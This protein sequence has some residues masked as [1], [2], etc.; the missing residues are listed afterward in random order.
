MGTG[1]AVATGG[2]LLAG[3]V[4]GAAVAGTA[5]PPVVG[6]GAGAV[7]GITVETRVAGGPTV[8]PQA[9]APRPLTTSTTTGT[10]RLE[11]VDGRSENSGRPGMSADA[12]C[13]VPSPFLK[14]S[15]PPNRASRVC[16]DMAT[17]NAVWR[18]PICGIRGPACGARPGAAIAP[19]PAWGP[20]LSWAL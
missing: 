6:I 19:A 4:G 3:A 11:R 17:E 12:P 2:R 15:G 13:D 9:L 14:R 5:V 10:A 1:G 18:S 20:R 16:R 8:T 7:I